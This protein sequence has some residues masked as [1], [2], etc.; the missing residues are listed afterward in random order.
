MSD[1][2]T[3]GRKELS[4]AESRIERFLRESLSAGQ[5][6]IGTI[7]LLMVIAA[8]IA[9]LPRLFDARP[10]TFF[11]F[12]AVA[13]CILGPLTV[14]ASNSLFPTFSV[15]H[16]LVFSGSLLFVLLLAW[17]PLMRWV[18]GTMSLEEAI[19][20][21]GSLLIAWAIQIAV[22]WGIWRTLFVERKRRYFN[23]QPRQSLDFDTPV[24]VAESP[25]SAPSTDRK[26]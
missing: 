22:L 2:E 8:V 24:D 18:G 17:L 15:R 25:P 9:T 19:T 6:R 3:S 10:D 12:V 16:R 20:A 14:L 21:I 7:L 1:S 5:F 4:R 26:E 23:E 11:G 13:A